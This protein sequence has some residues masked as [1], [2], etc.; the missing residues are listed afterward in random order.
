[1]K[2]MK[3]NAELFVR[4]GCRVYIHQ[5]LNKLQPRAIEG[6]LIG[7]TP[8]K[9]SFV[10]MRENTTERVNVIDITLDETEMPLKSQTKQETVEPTNNINGEQYTDQMDQYADHTDTDLKEIQE[11]EVEEI[12]TQQETQLIEHNEGIS[13]EDN[14]ENN[15]TV[16]QEDITNDIP[17]KT[18][19]TESNIPYSDKETS[20]EKS[21]NIDDNHIMPMDIDV[22]NIQT[23]DNHNKH[24]LRQRIIISNQIPKIPLNG[25][26]P[27]IR[28]K[29]VDQKIVPLDDNDAET[30]LVPPSFEKDTI[31]KLT[32][33]EKKH[34][35][36][37]Q[38]LNDFQKLTL[39]LENLY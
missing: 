20:Q 23:N 27:K 13:N 4:I 16:P 24:T 1:M 38:D 11:D 33:I 37:D 5:K 36:T 22:R 35:P 30:V 28:Y 3:P 10:V 12:T 8:N 29:V 26:Y 25:R 18:S 21:E 6:I 34:I 14:V 17:Q 15:E 39:D 31:Q 7:I 32:A 19:P 2:L 9:Q